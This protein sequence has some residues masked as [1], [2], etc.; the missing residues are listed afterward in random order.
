MLALLLHYLNSFFYLTIQFKSSF[1]PEA[2]VSLENIELI[3]PAKITFCKTEI[4]DRVEQIGLAN[5]IP[6]TNANNSLCKTEL[7]VKI[8]FELVE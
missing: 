6:S 7:L 5:T 4:V 8:I 3:V 1:Q 2:L